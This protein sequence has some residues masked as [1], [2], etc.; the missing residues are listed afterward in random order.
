MD[1]RICHECTPRESGN[2]LDAQG[3]ADSETWVLCHLL[4]EFIEER[5]L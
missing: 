5:V 3:M 1:R 2:I 4:F